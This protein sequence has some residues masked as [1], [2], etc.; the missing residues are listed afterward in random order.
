[1]NLIWKF[2]ALKLSILMRHRETLLEEDLTGETIF[3]LDP[4]EIPTVVQ[5]E[6]SRSK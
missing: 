2:T 6:L 4:A 5:D 3:E 1:M